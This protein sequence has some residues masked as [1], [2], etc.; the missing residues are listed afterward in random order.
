MDLTLV[1]YILGI[2]LMVSLVFFIFY[3]YFYDLIVQA[4]ENKTLK[5]VLG[6][7]LVLIGIAGIFLPILPGWLLIFFGLGWMRI[8]F[9]ERLAKRIARKFGVK[10]SDTE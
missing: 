10:V 2:G 1:T 7:I 6:A 9:L 3:M 5:R 8:Y 4:Y